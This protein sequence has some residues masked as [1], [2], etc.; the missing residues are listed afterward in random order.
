MRGARTPGKLWK[1][2]YRNE[3]VEWK[4]K[5]LKDRPFCGG[6]KGLKYIYILWFLKIYE[7]RRVSIPVPWPCEQ[8]AWTIRPQ[9]QISMLWYDILSGHFTNSFTHRSSLRIRRVMKHKHT[10]THIIHTYR[11]THTHR[12]TYR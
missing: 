10:F 12:Q 7:I 9:C 5:G 4:K 3:T 8:H 11:Q 2:M 6:E 1:T